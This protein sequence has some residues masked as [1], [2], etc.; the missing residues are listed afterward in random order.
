[1]ATFVGVFYAVVA[2]VS[3]ALAGAAGSVRMLLM[4]RW[5][6]FI[7]SGMAFA[8]HVLREASREPSTLRSTAS[9]A[10]LGAGIGGFGIALAA[11]VHELTAGSGYRLTILLALVTWPIVTAVP[12]FLLALVGA[13]LLGAMRRRA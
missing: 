7:V 1:M 8:W 6:A 3:G 11:N 2:V 10:A 9:H 5:L 13:T 4:W 12:A